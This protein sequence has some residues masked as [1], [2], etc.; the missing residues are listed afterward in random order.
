[1]NCCTH[2]RNS[3]EAAAKALGKVGPAARAAEPYLVRVLNHPTR[4]VRVAA[5]AALEAI[6][7][8]P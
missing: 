8:S 6:K 1:M 4:Q 3:P 7:A 5:A 2:Y